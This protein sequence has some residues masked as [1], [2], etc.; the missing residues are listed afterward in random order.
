[1]SVVAVSLKKRV[2]ISEPSGD[3]AVRARPWLEGDGLGAIVADAT[4]P[5]LGRLVEA[6]RVLAGRH[7][8]KRV[9]QADGMV[10]GG[11]AGEQRARHA[12]GHA[13]Q[14]ATA[15]RVKR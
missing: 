8:R 11:V 6:G 15:S 5:G 12:G 14:R 9:E 3:E 7:G 13:A 2:D 10:V 1:M 4:P